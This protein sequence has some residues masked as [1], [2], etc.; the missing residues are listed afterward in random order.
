MGHETEGGA[1]NIVGKGDTRLKDD[2]I[3]NL[4]FWREV[5]ESKDG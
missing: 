3:E 5:E 2:Q 1:N 4:F